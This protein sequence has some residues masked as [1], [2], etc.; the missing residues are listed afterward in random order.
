MVKPACWWI[1]SIPMPAARVVGYLPIRMITPISARRRGLMWL[2]Y[3][4]LTAACPNTTRRSTHWCPRANGSARVSCWVSG[5]IHQ[6]ED[7]TDKAQNG[8]G[9]RQRAFR[10]EHQIAGLKWKFRAET[11]RRMWSIQREHHPRAAQAARH[12][13]RGVFAQ[14]QDAFGIGAGSFTPPMIASVQRRDFVAVEGKLC[15]AQRRDRK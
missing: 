4:F 11:A 8:A 9:V 12:S 13:P 5:G 10:R 3:D 1:S 6:P 14:D 15:L 7:R 2:E